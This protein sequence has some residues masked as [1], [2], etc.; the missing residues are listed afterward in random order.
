MS[1][2]RS[3]SVVEE[4]P[5]D[6]AVEASVLVVDDQAP[7]R[8]SMVITFRREG[9]AVASAE[10]GHQALELLAQKPFDLIV[11][12]LRMTG[13]SG[14]DVLKKTKE[15]FPDTE[16]VVMTAYGTIEGAVDAI[17]S[18][19]YDYLTKPFQPEELT[20][21]AERALERKGLTQRVRR[22]EKEVRGDHPFEGIITASPG[23]QGVLR[24][25]EQVARLDS[26]VLI[27][28]ESGTGKEL[29]ARALHARSPRKDD[30]L[31]IVNCG[32]IPEN[33]QESEL[34]GHTKGSFTGAHADKPGLFDEADGGTAFLDEVGELTPMAQVKML[35]FLQNGEA[36]RVGTTLSRLLDVR[37]I[38]ATNR[39]LEKSV[40]DGTFRE[41][42]FYRLNVIPI[43][44]PPLRDR[45]EDI[46][47]LAQHFARRIA[48]RMGMAQPPPISP[49]AMDRLM[50][51]PWRGNVRELENIIE[52]AAA[53]DR[54]G[55]LGMD[56][57]PF[58]ETQ[59]KED[60]LID[61]ARQSLLTLQQ[62]EKEYILEVLAECNGSRKNTA[63][64]LGITTATLWRKLKLY[65][66]ENK[67]EG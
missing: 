61:K 46:P 49:R 17:K 47:P 38:A 14:I 1:Q 40:E 24:M 22:L 10:S 32:A 27:T 15:L 9:Y 26:T 33:L 65:E 50:K 13:M 48:D 20:L 44:I 4:S 55:I 25:I 12:D 41:D 16:V 35:R 7:I 11:T 57:L 42:L 54:D 36:R 62:L 56:D 58:G 59:R 18:G 53:L 52:R 60:K 39:D 67:S 31:V 63:R 2:N 21:V 66:R 45:Q 30:P 6:L 28:G 3:K 19:A 29:V 5:E 34:F 23:M 51:Q 37:I 64:R 43:Q 8:E